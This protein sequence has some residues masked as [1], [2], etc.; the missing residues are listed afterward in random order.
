MEY[1]A[2]KQR[3]NLILRQI[4]AVESGFSLNSINYLAILLRMTAVIAAAPVQEIKIR[5]IHTRTLLLSPV[6]TLS[7]LT[8]VA[9]IKV[10]GLEEP[11]EPAPEL[12]PGAVG[13]LPVALIS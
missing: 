6:E 3:K 2:E 9:G 1:P 12:L 11:E 10:E 8:E 5:A 7:V 13:C 4:L